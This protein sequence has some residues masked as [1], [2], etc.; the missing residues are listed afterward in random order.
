[1]GRDHQ[2][3]LLMSQQTQGAVK[4]C[5]PAGRWRLELGRQNQRRERE[6]EQ[7]EEQAEATHAGKV[8]PG[9]PLRK[10]GGD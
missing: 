7:G 10:A 4:R 2:D 5:V 3:A 6:K 1:M 9:A 8:I